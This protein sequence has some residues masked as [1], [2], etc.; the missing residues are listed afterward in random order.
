METR[1]LFIRKKV[2]F[3][4]FVF[5]LSSIWLHAEGGP[6]FIVHRTRGQ[7]VEYQTMNGEKAHYFGFSNISQHYLGGIDGFAMYK[8]SCTEPGYERCNAR[9]DG[10]KHYFS[11]SHFPDENPLRFYYDDFEKEFNDLIEISELEFFDG[12]LNGKHFIKVNAFSIE[13][14]QCYLEFS[15]IWNFNE[16]GDGE[17]QIFANALQ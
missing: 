11:V 10:R 17:I 9:H 13:G 3:S 4:I 15:I 1:S 12:K 6:I 8:V 7:V 14:E 16:K 2:L 5:V